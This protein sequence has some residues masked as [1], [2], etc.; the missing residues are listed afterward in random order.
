MLVVILT[1]HG[2]NPIV[3]GRE[4]EEPDETAYNRHFPV[5][6]VKISTVLRNT[7]VSLIELVTSCDVTRDTQRLH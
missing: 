1:K 3:M 4:H 5:E 6:I 7:I 2:F